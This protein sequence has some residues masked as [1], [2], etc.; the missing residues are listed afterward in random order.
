MSSSARIAC[1]LSYQES[2]PDGTCEKATTLTKTASRQ[3]DRASNRSSL[4]NR[5]DSS[6][7][8]GREGTGEGET[9]EL[10]AGI[11]LEGCCVLIAFLFGRGFWPCDSLFDEGT[12]CRSVDCPALL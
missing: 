8:V 5:G 7:G 1:G 3:L 6:P 4:F 10:L 12:R 2:M 9:G 11:F